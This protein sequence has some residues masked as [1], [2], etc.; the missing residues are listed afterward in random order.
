MGA[1]MSKDLPETELDEVAQTTNVDLEDESTSWL[2]QLP[3]LRRNPSE[4]PDRL[5]RHQRRLLKWKLDSKEYLSSR[6]SFLNNYRID[7]EI[8]EMSQY[9]GPEHRVE[10]PRPDVTHRVDAL[11]DAILYKRHQRKDRWTYVSLYGLDYEQVLDYR[12]HSNEL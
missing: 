2:L 11:T 7:S 3:S 8:R 5:Y 1:L 4:I 12:E 9:H 10:Y 6:R